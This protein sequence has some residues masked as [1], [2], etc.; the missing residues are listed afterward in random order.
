MPT[1]LSSYDFVTPAKIAAATDVGP[2]EPDDDE[3]NE[4]ES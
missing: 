1:E 2:G 4:V 3:G